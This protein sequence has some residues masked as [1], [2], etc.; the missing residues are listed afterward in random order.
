MDGSAAGEASSP[1]AEAPE[2]GHV[3]LEATHQAAAKCSKH[4]RQD[5]TLTYL[6][7]SGCVQVLLQVVPER[8]HYRGWQSVLL[9]EVFSHV[10]THSQCELLLKK[11][12][13][14]PDEQE[15][16]T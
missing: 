12:T 13:A 6:F 11:K 15:L 14:S 4:D 16:C 8:R 5:R 10:L 2:V 3:L 1:C 9:A 7:C